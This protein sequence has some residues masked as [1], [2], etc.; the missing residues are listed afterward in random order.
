MTPLLHTP[1]A[2]A[3]AARVPW[4]D[5]ILAGLIVALAWRALASRDL[6]RS[7][8][9]FIAFGLAV[10]LAWARMGAVDVALAEAAIGTGLLGVLLIDAIATLGRGVVAYR[11]QRRLAALFLL[12]SAALL[13]LLWLATWRMPAGGG[14]AAEAAARMNESGVAHPV[15]AVLLNF[16][17][18]DTWLEI[19]VLLLAVLAMLAAR[20][21]PRF[22]AA[23]PAPSRGKQDI[24]LSRLTRLLIPLMVLVGGAVLWL[25]ESRPGGAFQAGVILAAALILARLA[26]L[27]ALDRLPPQSWRILATVGFAA[28][29]FFATLALASGRSLLEYHPESAGVVI[30]LIETAC[31]LSIGLSLAA[32]HALP[33]GDVPAPERRT[34]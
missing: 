21:D 4:F 24:L 32:F 30:F 3:S 29:F 17:G 13:P 5:L 28:F 31:T 8:V 11:P 20:G 15:T 26:G 14:L 27:P 6:S 19:A 33:G 2:S 16:R 22:T 23:P 7:A 10:A 34:G 1:L 18:Y 25:G 12:L 9:F